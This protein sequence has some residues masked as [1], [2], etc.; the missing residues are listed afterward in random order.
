MIYKIAYSTLSTRLA[1]LI[2]C[3]KLEPINER[4]NTATS[5]ELL[6]KLVCDISHAVTYSLLAIKSKENTLLSVPSKVWANFAW[7]HPKS[8]IFNRFPDFNLNTSIITKYCNG[9]NES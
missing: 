4:Q 6:N 3:D 1:S 5:I 8:A 7:P 2:N 9:Y